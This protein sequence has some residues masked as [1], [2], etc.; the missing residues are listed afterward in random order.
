MDDAPLKVLLVED[1]E[2]DY[3][4]A[5]E[6]LSEIPSRT[7][8]LDRVAD[9]ES[10]RAAM[11]DRKH[12]LY[13]IDYRLGP[14]SGMELLQE[15]VANDC[16]APIILLT[17]VGDR[18]IDLAAMKAGAADY[19]V[20]GQINASTL[21]R[22]ISHSLQRKESE[23]KLRASEE[24]LRLSQKL[25]SVGTL[26]GGVAHDFNNLLTIIS[27]Y[28][29]RLRE[30]TLKPEHI[31]KIAGAIEQTVQ[32]GASL[33]KQI[34]TF[35]RES[36]VEFEQ[37][38]INGVVENWIRMLEETFPRSVQF[39]RDLAPNL[40]PIMADVTQLHQIL[41][42]LCVNARDAMNGKGTISISTS[43]V[44]AQKLPERVV[45]ITSDNYVLLQV[46]DT[47]CG[48]DE[49]T[50]K[51]IF[52]PFF[53]TKDKDQGTGLGMAVVY[54]IVSSHQAHIDL[55]SSPGCGATFRIF[56]PIDSA[57]RAS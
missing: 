56:F 55:Q 46:S 25:E 34:L 20:K 33:V 8:Q 45:D 27:A 49:E 36:K 41:L 23:R 53:T 17:G 32:R 6:Y 12:D 11:A 13:L 40:P 48:M 2:D 52:D 51:R 24:R 10:A 22:S 4:I 28:A 9:Y 3:I 5:R 14:H 15:A 1:D 31:D 30:P 47:G 50:K 39:T 21:E 18:N 37:V 57:P 26:A 19:L 29:G 54:G 16:P 44:S 35:A 38:E 7:I 43:L 42:N